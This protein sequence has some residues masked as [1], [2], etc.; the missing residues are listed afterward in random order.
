[1]WALGLRNPFRFDIK[2]DTPPG[3]ILV[4]GCDVGWATYEE[5]N[6]VQAGAN[7]GWP[8]W[9][10]LRHLLVYV[11]DGFTES[12]VRHEGAARVWRRA[13]HYVH[14]PPP[15]PAYARYRCLEPS[16]RL[17]VFAS[18]RYRY[19]PLHSHIFE[20]QVHCYI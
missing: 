1:M 6:I 19:G 16:E 3:T 15:W 4:V 13:S 18:W 11:H 10:G 5:I 7:L 17:A 8:C 12:D 2:P 9:E 20:P 14:Q